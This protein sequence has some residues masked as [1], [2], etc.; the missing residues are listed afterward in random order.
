MCGELS[1]SELAMRL[2]VSEGYIHTEMRREH[3]VSAN[4]NGRTV[5][6]LSA[7]K[8]HLIRKGLLD[9]GRTIL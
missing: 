2:G 6:T 9:Q 3:L 8:E 5:I 4:V 1:P 7:L